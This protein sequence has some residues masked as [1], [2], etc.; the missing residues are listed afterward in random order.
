MT[1]RPW[2]VDDDLWARIEPLLPPWPERSPGPKPVDDRLCLQGI[3]YVL[4]QDIAWQLLPLELGFGSGQTCWRRLNR[5][6]KAGVFEQLHRLLLAELNAAG[7]LDWSRACVDGPRPRE[8]GGAAT[9]PSPV[10]R[11][12]TG[13]KHHLICD[14]KGTPLKVITT[15][16]NVN[17]ITQTLALVDGVPPVAGRPGHPRRRPD[18]VLGDKAYDSLAVRRELRKRRIMPVI[19]H[20]G[21]PDIKGLGKLRY[22]VEQ[23]FALLHQFKRLAV[24]WER[25]LELHDAFLSLGCSL[26]CWRRLKKVLSCWN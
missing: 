21:T 5:W 19:S 8:K 7:E 4:H 3:L 11:R 13:S 22:V 23:T 26:I 1:T 10:D 12:K 20:R 2:T 9:G 14:G 16:A 25:R 24:R 17:D 15:A 18:A 6:Q